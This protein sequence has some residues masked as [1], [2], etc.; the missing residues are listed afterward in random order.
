MI[1]CI[2]PNPALDHTVVVDTFNPGSVH[3]VTSALLAAGGKG[4][5][6]LR[7][8]KLLGGQGLGLGF[9]GG[10]TGK[11]IAELC[12][13]EQLTAVW[14]WIENE[15]RTCVIIVDLAQGHATVINEKGAHTT[16]ED[17]QRLTDDVQRESTAASALCFSGSLPPGITHHQYVDLL[18]RVNQVGRT[19]WVDTSGESLRAAIH[20]P[21]IIIKVN[22]DEAGAILGTMVDSPDAALQAASTLRTYGPSAVVI[23]L[24]AKGAVFA[25]GTGSWYAQPPAIKA[26]DAVGSGDSFLAGIAHAIDQGF[27]PGTA[28]RYGVAAGAANAT[29]V[30]GGDFPLDTFHHCL[31]NTRLESR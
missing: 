14:T 31:E 2:S 18:S 5:N 19:V 3:R 8:I 6:V 11:R 4:I 23:T 10:A 30:G 13:H 22:G 26:I 17:W 7:A 27:D 25:H 16:N 28:L 29:T 9:L 15:T 12:D 24:G 20:I 1:L 21:G